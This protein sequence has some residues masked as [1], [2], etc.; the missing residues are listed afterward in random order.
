MGASKNVAAGA[1]SL[2]RGGLAIVIDEATDSGDLVLAAT[3]VSGAGVNALALHARGLT[4][5]A[6]T[7]AQVSA[8][9]LPPMSAWWSPPG[10]SFT[11]SIEARTGVTTGIS[12]RDRAETVR[13]VVARDAG[14][15]DWVSPG[16]VFPLRAPATSLASARNRAVAALVLARLAGAGD[17]AVLSQILDDEGELARGPYLRSLAARLGI[18]CVDVDELAAAE[19]RASRLET[20]RRRQPH[21]E[22]ASWV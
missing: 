19:G 16:H 10:K 5:L 9:G 22:K 18:A 17:G 21:K 20:G 8:L 2:G 13:A 4:E 6:L 7:P 12:A 3:R 14:P 1:A 11:V 15:R